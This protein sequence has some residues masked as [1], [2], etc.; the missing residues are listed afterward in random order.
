MVR[1][2]IKKYDGK[3][4][5]FSPLEAET[6]IGRNDPNSGVI[7]QINLSDHTVSRHHAKIYLEKYSFIIEDMGSANGT[8][9][10]EHKI[11][12]VKLVPGDQITIGR[13]IIIFESE[14]TR[15]INPLDFTVD[16]EKLDPKKTID[17]NYFILQKLS[18]LLTVT[19]TLENFLQAV[20][21]MIME[22]IKASRGAL[23]LLDEQGKPKDIVTTGGKVIFSE[24]AVNQVLSQKKSLLVGYDFEASTTMINRGI[25]SA[26]CA[27]ILKEPRVY[28]VIYLEDPLPG[29]FGEE[30]LVILTLF[31]NQLA[32]GIENVFLSESI[33]K[34]FTIRSNLE[35]FLSPR[36][37]EMVTRDCLDGG[38]IFLKTNRMDATIIFSDVKGF[39]RLSE[40]LDPQEIAD[41]LSQHFSLMTEVIFTNEGTLDKYVGD[42]LV[43]IFGAPFPCEDHAHRAVMA[44]L[45][46][47][48][49]QEKFSENLPPDKK[50]AIRIG[51]NTGAI[52]AGYMGSPKRM[53]YTVLGEP[54]IIA[55]RLQSLA[56]PNTIYLGRETYQRV[57]DQYAGEFV[58]KMKT[59]KGLKEMEIYRLIG[60]R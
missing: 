55:Q 47:L 42:G 56:D 26:I 24:E 22:S 12:K 10:N 4:E 14:G 32:A 49:Q 36:V 15:T 28:G 58:T 38:E 25:H 17:S 39:T 1:L 19:T 34:E 45:Q 29:R 54:V 44:G 3:Q 11:S 37:V 53:E 41:I 48:E 59:P 51:I 31:A 9:V 20:I 8:W 27:P 40:K 57:K 6:F 33:Q 23:I 43:A 7:N 13:N 18:K 46:M 35:R 16:E 21:Q 30:E 52:I 5:V 50:F 2:V 60:I